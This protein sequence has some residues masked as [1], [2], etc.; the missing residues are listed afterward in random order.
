LIIKAVLFDL[1]ET[2]IHR[3]T[4]I[5]NFISDQFARFATELAPLTAGQY[6]ERFLDLEDQG[7]ADKAAVYPALVSALAIAGVSSDLLLADYRARYPSFAVLNPGATQ[8]LQSLRDR[9]IKLGIVTNGNAVVQNGKIDATGLRPLLSS[10]IISELVGLRKPDP[11][12]FNLAAT[13]LGLTTADCM[14][15]GDNP[16]VDVGGSIAAGMRGVWFR[17]GGPW[18]QSLPAPR[19]IIDRLLECLTMADLGVD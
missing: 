19:Y 15:V 10:V 17:A 4:A 16:E 12:I 1:D 13:Q 11:A 18:P 14:F 7:R 9:G 3:D 8:T 5:R 2:L 6:A